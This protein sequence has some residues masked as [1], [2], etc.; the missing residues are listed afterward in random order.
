MTRYISLLRFTPQGVR[1]LKQSPTRAAA[2]RKAA[3]KAGVKV[4]TQLWTVG[5]YDGILVLSAANEAAVLSAIAKLA[6]AGNVT[7]QT[8]QAFDAKEFGK[9]AS[10]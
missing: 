3:E 8:L 1:N 9:I 10:R 2:F 5:T 4:E 7:T 6:A